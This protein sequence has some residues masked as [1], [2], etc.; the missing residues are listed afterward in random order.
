MTILSPSEFLAARLAEDGITVNHVLR[1][2]VPDKRGLVASRRTPKTILFLGMLEVLKGPQILLEAFARCKDD[3][4][5]DLCILGEGSLKKDLMKRAST[6]GLGNRTKIP[7]FVP[8]EQLG[9][10]LEETAS[11]VIP[12]VAYENAP[13]AALEAFSMGI[14][15][16]GSNLGGLPE[17]LGSESGSMVFEGGSV[18]SLATSL[19][20][21]WDER[22]DLAGR[23]KKARDC[24]TDKYSPDIHMREYLGII[25]RIER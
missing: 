9:S 17:I 14:P 12:T 18:E 6:L 15:V 2:F 3:H 21:L 11:I 4:E 24:Y 1:N 23:G 20:L 19:R 13:L 25:G 5:F 16:L 10:V 7:G 8:L 22:A